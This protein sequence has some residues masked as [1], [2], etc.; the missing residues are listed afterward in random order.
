MSTADLGESI[1]SIVSLKVPTE[2][3]DELPTLIEN[4]VRITQVQVS[5]KERIERL[6]KEREDAAKAQE[7]SV[8]GQLRD[9]QAKRFSLS[10]THERLKE[11]MT[12][13]NVTTKTPITT[14]STPNLDQKANSSPTLRYITGSHP[15]AHDPAPTVGA[16]STSSESYS[17]AEPN[18]DALKWARLATFSRTIK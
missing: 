9:A 7:V 3:D 17:S 1:P 5:L 16:A 18:S 8:Q 15:S 12:Q 11:R 13:A 14:D 6:M 4:Y 2:Q 10:I